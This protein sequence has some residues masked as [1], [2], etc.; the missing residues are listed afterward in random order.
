[1]HLNRLLNTETGKAFV[2]ILLGLGLAS[3][4]RRV[5]NEDKC[6]NFN[7]PI[8]DEVEGKIFK[9]GDKCYKYEPSQAKCEPTKKTV[10]INRKEPEF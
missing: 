4:F 6:L 5:C 3:L 10:D 7:G 2:T 9:S 8:L 1:M